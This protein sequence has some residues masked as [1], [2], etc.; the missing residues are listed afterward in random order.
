[1]KSLYNQPIFAQCVAPVYTVDHRLHDYRPHDHKPVRTMAKPVVQLSDFDPK[2]L[3]E[4]A[5][6]ERDLT[7]IYQYLQAMQDHFD[8]ATWQ[9]IALGGYYGTSALLH[10]VVELRILLDRDP[11]L[12]TRSI[13]EIKEIARSVLNHD[14]HIR[15]LETEYG[16]LPSTV[17]YRE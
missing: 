10:E 4:Y 5:I 3:I 1:M 7:S 8:M 9:E 17:I 14:A 13:K 15:G 16:Y 2:P 6:T 11:Y 12:L